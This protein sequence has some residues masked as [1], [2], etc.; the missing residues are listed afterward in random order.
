[1][2]TAPE[3][4]CQTTTQLQLYSRKISP[5]SLPDNR[6]RLYVDFFLKKVPQVLPYFD[7]FPSLKVEIFQHATLDK[8][9]L[10][11]ILSVSHLIY[12]CRMKNTSRPAAYH[13]IHAMP[14][15]RESIMAKQIPETVAITVSLLAWIH[16]VRFHDKEALCHLNGLKEILKRIAG[17]AKLSP[18]LMQIYRFSIW[19]EID[20]SFLFFPWT[21][22][23]RYFGAEGNDHDLAW[24]QTCCSQT[25]IDWVLA[26]LSL[27]DIMHRACELAID[28]YRVRQMYP[29]SERTESY[30]AGRAVGILEELF[31]WRRQPLRENA[32][33][34]ENAANLDTTDLKPQFLDY[35]PL[36]VVN[37]FYTNLVIIS[38]SLEILI[39]LIYSPII[40]Q[41]WRRSQCAIDICRRYG[42]LPVNENTVAIGKVTTVFLT[43]V[44]LG[45]KRK[46]PRETTWLIQNVFQPLIEVWPIMNEAAV[47]HPSK[48]R[49]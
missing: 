39:D 12:S 29:G 36:R 8:G 35:P 18:M 25:E 24:I 45:G 16:V 17:Q 13:Y 33:A 30:I 38:K 47:S 10:H 2:A 32:E 9:L 19:I 37:P 40:D 48:Y 21:E 31:Q 11:A 4:V 15:I 1:M 27:D 42:A 5:I 23:L 7:V 34:I 46:S 3:S 26:N 28:A 6:E 41:N 20:A 43:G 49:D 22:S 14:Y 44:A